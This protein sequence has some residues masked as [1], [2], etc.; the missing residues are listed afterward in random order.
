MEGF[1]FVTPVTSL[2]RTN[3]GKEDDDD[4]SLDFC[5]HT[6]EIGSFIINVSV[7]TDTTHM[8]PLY[9]WR[10]TVDD[11]RPLWNI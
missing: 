3:T 1:S 2:N 7:Y 9:M 11:M 4:R 8:H 10:L 6:E 5:L